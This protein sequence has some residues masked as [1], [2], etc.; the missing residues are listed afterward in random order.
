MKAIRYML[1]SNQ[2][3][4]L[5]TALEHPLWQMRVRQAI[6]RSRA[7]VGRTYSTARDAVALRWTLWQ[8]RHGR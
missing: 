6:M 4:R 3:F 1:G 5:S 7:A 2:D 8:M